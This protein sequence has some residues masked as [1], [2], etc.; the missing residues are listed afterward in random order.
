MELSELQLSRIKRTK[1][2]IVDDLPENLQI[3][4]NTLRENGF[5]IAFATSGKQA[6]S[7]AALKNPNLILLD[8]TMPE[9]D[10]LTVCKKLKE[11]PATSSIP[12]IFLTA[13]TETESIMKALSLGA[14]DYVV[15]PFNSSSLLERIFTHLGIDKINEAS[16]EEKENMILSETSALLKKEFVPKCNEVRASMFIDDV[17]AFAK[18]LI[19]LGKQNQVKALVEYGENLNENANSLRIAKMTEM[20]DK[21]PVLIGKISR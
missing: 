20:L 14:V 15:K 3:L 5:Q 7:V 10:G 2:L 13:R 19:D 8:M 18:S 16:S 11:N 6:L 4:G 12:I 21:F 17:V 1:I 9:M